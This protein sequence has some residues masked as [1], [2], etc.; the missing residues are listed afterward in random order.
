MHTSTR[1]VGLAAGA[2]V[3]TASI[4][5]LTTTTPASAIEVEIGS[6]FPERDDVLIEDAGYFIAG[7]GFTDGSPDSPATLTWNHSGTFGTFPELEGKLHFEGVDNC[8]RVRLVALN[9]DGSR[10]DQD[11]VD[12]D[13]VCPPTESHFARDIELDGEGPLGAPLSAAQVRV[14]LQTEPS[15]GNWVNAE[16]ETFVFGPNLDS[17]TAQIKRAEWDLGADE[18]Q[19]GAPT[20][21][22]SV[23]WVANDDGTISV[24]MNGTLYARE[25][26]DT[27]GR[28]EIRYKDADGDILETRQGT[29]HCMENDDLTEF[30][31]SNG[32][33]F[34]HYAL[35]Q[36]TYAIM[37]DG[38]QLGAT[39]VELG[40]PLVVNGPVNQP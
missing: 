23:E 39:T 1:R 24:L 2:L 29:E 17:D 35:R 4:F 25:A 5:S 37:K 12:S 40:D 28:L 22:A 15:P 8:A 19:G 11:P 16:S 21:S 18:W 10:T 33:N 9:A 6:T 7:S 31:V 32:Q 30:V 36:V 38:V 27:C 13:P 20:G 3:A 34:S 14:V 26:D